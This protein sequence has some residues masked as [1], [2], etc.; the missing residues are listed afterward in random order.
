MGVTVLLIAGVFRT[1]LPKWFIG[2]CIATATCYFLS[3]FMNGIGLSAGLNIKTAITYDINI[4]I[5]IVA[6]SIDRKKLI[7]Y[8]VGFVT[9]ISAVS[10]VFYALETI[11]GR[12]A[13]G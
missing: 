13:I 3:A 12:D 5:I 4:L 9:V 1:G 2:Y 10:L 11:L 6:Y 8:F 7:N